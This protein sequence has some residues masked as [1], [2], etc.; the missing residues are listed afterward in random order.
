MRK[1]QTEHWDLVDDFFFHL[2]KTRIID[3]NV[4]QLDTQTRK[5]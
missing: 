3:R 5:R 4:L 1:M 2:W